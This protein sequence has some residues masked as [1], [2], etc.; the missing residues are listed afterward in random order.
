MFDYPTTAAI[1]AHALT[2]LKPKA[3]AAAAA[4]PRP[5]ARPDAISHGEED[6]DVLSALYRVA[7]A[8]QAVS[9][10]QAPLTPLTRHLAPS[11]LRPEV[12][13]GIAGLLFRPLLA[14]TSPASLTAAVT[15]GGHSRLPLE[16]AIVPIPLLRWDRHPPGEGSRGGSRGS[17]VPSLQPALDAQFG[18][19]WEAAEVFDAAAF[20]LSPQEALSMDPQHRLLL[21]SASELMS[22]DRHGRTGSTAGAGAGVGVFIGISWTEYHRLGEAHLGP[23]GPY[24]A[25]GAVLR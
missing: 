2:K 20:G 15:G 13:V 10:G 11:V 3:V 25:Q 7:A 23:G 1:T 6:D 14:A 19:V 12:L 22:A 5:A 17:S 8:P 9:L 21:E 24:A 18:A 16:D 4:M